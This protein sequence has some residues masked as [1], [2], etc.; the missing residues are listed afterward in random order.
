MIKS[1]T[2]FVV[3]KLNVTFAIDR[4]GFV[5]PDGET[6]HGVYDISFL[7]TLP[8]MVLMMPKDERELRDMMQ[9]ALEYND[10][11][12]AYRYPRISGTGS[13]IVEAPKAIPLGTWELLRNGDYA[14]VLAVG[15]MVQIAEEAA[16]QLAR[17]ASNL[18]IVNAR[19]IKPL[20]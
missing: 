13:S 5:G 17:K 18:R 15:P 1:F 19:F 8:N 6:H 7:R 12:I 9:T 20:G 3:L 10:G 4:A 14:A 11:P 2:T 16:E